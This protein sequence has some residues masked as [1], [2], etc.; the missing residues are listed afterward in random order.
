MARQATYTD[1]M[2]Q[3]A[4]LQS[5]A[6]ELRKKEV[7]GVIESIQEQMKMYNLSPEDLETKI[8]TS[9]GRRAGSKN[10]GQ[11]Q[12]PTQA[13]NQSHGRSGISNMDIKFRHPETGATWSGRGRMPK[14]IKE[15]VEQGQNKQTFAI[16]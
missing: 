14:W 1:L 12:S 2:S 13:T 6:Q 10:Q 11:Q 7:S 9:R 4:K 16:S 8:P 5:E 3:I 15:A